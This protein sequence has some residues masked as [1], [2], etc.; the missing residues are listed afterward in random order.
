MLFNKLSARIKSKVL[1]NPRGPGQRPAGKQH[2][3]GRINSV[4]LRR[5]DPVGGTL[6][7]EPGNLNS[8]PGSATT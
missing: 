3:Y 4:T 5:E 7:L 6:Y 2:I 8:V 1:R